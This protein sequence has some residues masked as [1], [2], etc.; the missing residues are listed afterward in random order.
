MHPSRINIGRAETDITP[1]NQPV[2]LRGQMYVRVSEGV[3]DPLKASV[4]VFESQGEH[5]VFVACDLL[6][7]FVELRD[8]VRARLQVP[9]LDPRKIILH[10]THTHTAP[11][12]IDTG[13]FFAELGVDDPPSVFPP[14][15]YISWAA[16]RIEAA[17]RQAWEKRAPGS[18]AF[19]HDVAVVGRN[20]RWVDNDGGANMYGG[21]RNRGLNARNQERFSHIEGYED[22][23][24][25]LLSTYDADGRLTGMIVN[26]PSPSQEEEHG[27]LISADFWHEARRELRKRHGEHVFVLPQ[28]SA[29]GDQTS[30]LI[31]ENKAHERMLELRGRTA[32][33]EIAMRIAEA[34]DRILPYLDGQHIDS[35]VLAHHVESLELP[36]NPLS[37]KQRDD[38]LT[39]VVEYRTAFEREKLLLQTNPDLRKQPRWWVDASMP[40]SRMMRHVD[41]VERFEAQK[42]RATQPMDIHIV[43]LGEVAFASNAVEYYLDFGIQ[44]KVRSPFIQTFLVQL[45]GDGTYVPSARSVAGGG[46][47]SVPISNVLGVEAGERIRDRTVELLKQLAAPTTP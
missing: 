44:I 36:L 14:S 20:R 2:L 6:S 21:E 23:S 27:L 7:G 16:E 37:E 35:P 3:K 4:A 9:G 1:V 31:L 25:K 8:A 43:R 10:A 26:L 32:R 46:Y 15:A 38:A 24:L 41:V 19:G 40:W 30:H 18:I 22:H 34:V 12:I 42:A 13:D 5:V 28:C 45:T 11:Q 29:G 39:Q 17:V 47:G 33:E